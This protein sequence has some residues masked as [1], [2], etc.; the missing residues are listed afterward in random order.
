MSRGRLAIFQRDTF[1]GTQVGESAI[2]VVM[3]KEVGIAWTDD[4]GSRTGDEQV[5]KAI[6][7]VVSP[8][9]RPSVRVIICPCRLGDIGEGAIAIISVKH[10]PLITVPA[11]DA[12]R[13]VKIEQAVVVVIAPG[14]ALGV[15]PRS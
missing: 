14:K 11:G 10:V 4:P 13:N 8:D 12:M 2:A 3:V 1:F 7:I 9:G 15:W 6:V 5:E